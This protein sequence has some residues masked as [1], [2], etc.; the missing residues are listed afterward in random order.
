MQNNY[1]PKEL[2]A[3]KK[4]GAYTLF[5]LAHGLREQSSLSNEEVENIAEDLKKFF[6]DRKLPP[7]DGTLVMVALVHQIAMQALLDNHPTQ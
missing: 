4:V 3:A 6:Q 5:G 2:E 7:V 1:T